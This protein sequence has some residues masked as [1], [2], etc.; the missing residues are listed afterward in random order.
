MKR[1]EATR[2]GTWSAGSVATWS[3]SYSGG[4]GDFTNTYSV[5]FDGVDDY[6]GMALP[7]VFNDIGSN[8]FS[9][10]LW[11]E[12]DDLDLN[13]VYTRMF[14]AAYDADNFVQFNI[15][16]A[17]KPQLYVEDGNSSYLAAVDSALN[18]GQWYHMVG[19]WDASANDAKLYLDG[20]L[21]SGAGG[22]TDA[23]WGSV[24][25]AY[26][27]C[28]GGS[29]GFYEGNIDEV[30]VFTSALSAS[31]I[32]AIY[33]GGAPIDLTSY[34]PVSWWRMGDNND[35]AGT[36]ISD[37]VATDS[38]ALY[39][40]GVAANYASV[41]DSAALDGFGDFTL[42]VDD[43]TLPDWTPSA[44]HYL[45]TKY[46]A[47]VGGRA[48]R[49][50]IAVDGTIGIRLSFDG[51]ANTLYSSTVATG[52]S[53]GAT[54]SIRALRTG[55]TLRF[56]VDSGS[57][58]VQLGADVA[59]VSTTLFGA[60]S[61]LAVGSVHGGGVPGVIG[62]I[63]RARIWSDATQTTNVLDINF[64]AAFRSETSFTATSGQTVTVHTT[65][66]ADYAVI[67]KKTDG[68]LVNDPVIGTDVPVPSS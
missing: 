40:P 1:R 34:S 48:Y 31:D 51:A 2:S 46:E 8:D 10:S 4:G 9:V 25:N 50:R 45:I 37:E 30:G 23:G 11:F 18:T 12:A 17:G 65:D 64:A 33:G 60:T 42:Q 16:A 20:A 62:S 54:A 66:I 58:F 43:V 24:Q 38:N 52:L 27:A 61:E 29:S 59:G 68:I 5:L 57:G 63:G 19:V 35:G 56:Y 32:T 67:R 39:L 44:I 21:Q 26:L 3:G 13:S 36:L 49:F 53:A 14:E 55:S 7:T 41:P 6:M 15:G 22:T 28:R 47:A